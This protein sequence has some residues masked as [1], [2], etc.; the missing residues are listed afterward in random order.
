MSATDFDG[1]AEEI[2]AEL[3]VPSAPPAPTLF[4]TDDPLLVIERATASRSCSN[5][6]AAKTTTKVHRGGAF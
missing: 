3:V 4:R 1:T 2:G 6:T 5:Q